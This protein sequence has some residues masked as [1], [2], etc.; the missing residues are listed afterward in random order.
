[1]TGE[2]HLRAAVAKLQPDRGTVLPCVC[3]IDCLWASVPWRTNS[4]SRLYPATPPLPLSAGSGPVPLQAD[5]LWCLIDGWIKQLERRTSGISHR[6]H[7]KCIFA[8]F[9]IIVLSIFSSQMSFFGNY[10]KA[11]SEHFP[12]MLIIYCFS[13]CPA[14]STRNNLYLPLMRRLGNS[15]RSCLLTSRLPPRRDSLACTVHTTHAK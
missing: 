6:V 7:C 3:A 9:I 14:E 13:A 8:V 2:S 15:P 4:L 10:I 1:M 5:K 11:S 12:L